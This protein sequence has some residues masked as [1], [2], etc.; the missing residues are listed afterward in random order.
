MLLLQIL[1][2]G[3]IYNTI[4]VTGLNLFQELAHSSSLVNFS[5]VYSM[6]DCWSKRWRRKR[7]TQSGKCLSVKL[8]FK[9]NE[10]FLE[11]QFW[12]FL[13]QAILKSTEIFFQY[14]ATLFFFNTP[15]YIHNTAYLSHFITVN[16]NLLQYHDQLLLIDSRKVNPFSFIRKHVCKYIQYLQIIY[17]PLRYAAFQRHK[18]ESSCLL[19]TGV[20]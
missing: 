2:H 9:R 10:L 3:F 15:C 12:L 13:E 17:S 6:L 14:Y 18:I 7:T 4:A 11:I 8:E 19:T 5:S 1:L 16:N 20:L